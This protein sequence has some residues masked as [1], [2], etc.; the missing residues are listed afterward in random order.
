[1]SVRLLYYCAAPNQKHTNNYHLCARLNDERLCSTY[2]VHFARSRFTLYALLYICWTRLIDDVYIVSILICIEIRYARNVKAKMWC[3]SMITI[4]L[5]I[6]IYIYSVF[7][8]YQLTDLFL[9][10]HIHMYRYI[11]HTQRMFDTDLHK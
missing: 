10:V 8:H 1:M 3:C 6:A 5:Y 2:P 7:V 9:Y 11:L 4:C